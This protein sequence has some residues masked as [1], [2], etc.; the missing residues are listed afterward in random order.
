MKRSPTHLAVIIAMTAACNG[1]RPVAT[2]SPST[3]TSSLAPGVESMVIGGSAGLT[4]G[5]R[6]QLRAFTRRTDGSAEEVTSKADWSSDKTSVATAEPGGWVTGVGPGSAKIAARYEGTES[7]FDVT[8]SGDQTSS[9]NGTAGSGSS[10][11]TQ[12]GGSSTSS[13]SSSDSTACLPPPLP[14][15]LPS[16]LPP[17][18]RASVP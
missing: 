8:V 4:R 12:G 7:L 3:V 15:E 10:S 18:P 6:A 5:G 16:P 2:T 13:N 1:N 17:C 14:E 11:A 9:S